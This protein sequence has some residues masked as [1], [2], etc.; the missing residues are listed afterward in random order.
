MGKKGLSYSALFAYYNRSDCKLASIFIQYNIGI[1]NLI[2]SRKSMNL[3]KPK[4]SIFIIIFISITNVLLFKAHGSD[5]YTID[6]TLAVIYHPESTSII[7][8]SD[9][10]PGLDGI[11]KTVNQVVLDGLMKLD[12]QKLKINIGEA[13]IDRY[14]AQVQKQN[15]LS[16]EDTIKLFKQMGY[17]YEQ[18][19][20][21]LKNMQLIDTLLDYRVKGK[22]VIDSKDVEKYYTDHPAYEEGYF[23]V[24]QA[25]V[26]FAGSSKHIKKALVN[27]AIES[28]EILTTTKWN[29]PFQLKSED[30]AKEKEYIKELAQ[31]SVVI[32]NED[33][34][35]I[36]L[37][38]LIS[39]QPKKLISLEERRKEITGILSQERFEKV[40]KEYQDK[41]IADSHIKYIDSPIA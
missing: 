27:Q 41:L 16:L 8:Q 36:T 14:L 17:T 26:S 33:D 24:A 9:L 39:K 4:F 25:F 34:D 15:N 30:F 12:A 38:H 11:S 2:N 37:L 5:L 18:G 7:L 3:R 23:T 32:L 22:V 10:R 40:L 21:Q 20:E 6:K 1:F 13:E 28:Q 31:G 35:G 29:K 19:R